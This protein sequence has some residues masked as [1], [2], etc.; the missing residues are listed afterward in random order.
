M[1]Q[2]SYVKTIDTVKEYVKI[3]FLLWIYVKMGTNSIIK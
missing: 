2:W 1:N 3:C